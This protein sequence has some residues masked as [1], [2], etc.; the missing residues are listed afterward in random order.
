LNREKR[1]RKKWG[2]GRER[3]S[4]SERERRKLWR[5][6]SEI[7]LEIRKASSTELK[8]Y[9]KL[10]RTNKQ[11]SLSISLFLSFCSETLNTN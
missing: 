4:E 5:E 2:G 1:E 10:A 9:R 6:M 11:I 7:V 3:E 8:V